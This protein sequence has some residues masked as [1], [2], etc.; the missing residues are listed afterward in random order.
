[1]ALFHEV[2]ALPQPG[3]ALTPWQT[4]F[5][6]GTLSRCLGCK[7]PTMRVGLHGWANGQMILDRAV[8]LESI[9]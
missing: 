3:R 9:F 2:D 7:Q 4:S 1:V 5:R 8:V 6:S